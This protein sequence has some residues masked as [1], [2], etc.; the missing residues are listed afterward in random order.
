MRIMIDNYE[1]FKISICLVFYTLYFSN[2]A[3]VGKINEFLIIFLQNFYNINTSGLV[4]HI[5][6]NNAFDND[7]NLNYNEILLEV[8]K[9]KSF[10]NKDLE[11]YYS[12]D[13]MAECITKEDSRLDIL[14]LMCCE[15]K[16]ESNND[17]NSEISLT[18][19]LQS[20]ESGK[21]YKETLIREEVNMCAE[22]GSALYYPIKNKN[23]N[24]LFGN[25]NSY[26]LVRYLF[27]IYERLS[28]V[29][30]CY[31]LFSSMNIRLTLLMF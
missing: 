29:R 11:K 22:V 12:F 4:K 17:N 15:T 2:A 21:T 18:P 20:H 27:S 7:K 8:M 10:D 5:F 16:H 19:S 6:N 13:K 24:L 26:I 9:N 25:E 23:D 3:E 28:K 30:E 31:Y 1:I 14:N